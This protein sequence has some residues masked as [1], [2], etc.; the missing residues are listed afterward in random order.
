MPSP[1]SGTGDS[2]LVVE[3]VEIAEVDL[4]ETDLERLAL[5]AGGRGVE[6]V[7]AFA[8]RGAGHGPQAGLEVLHDVGAGHELAQR[9]KLVEPVEA[10]PLEEQRGGAEQDRLAG[11]RVLPHLGDE[12]ALVERA[13][14]RRRR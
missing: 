4:V 8:Q 9:R 3:V 6:L 7:E 10:E 13:D 12:A 14:R 2:L 5:A 1:S 11:T